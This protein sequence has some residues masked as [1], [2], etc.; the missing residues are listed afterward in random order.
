MKPGDPCTLVCEPDFGLD[1]YGRLDLWRL[2]YEEALAGG[3][4]NGAVRGA[5]SCSIVLSEERFTLGVAVALLVRAI[6]AKEG[7]EGHRG[8]AVDGCRTPTEVG[9][10]GRSLT[11]SSC[12]DDDDDE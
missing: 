11:W 3:R 4:S 6:P 8:S 1:S 7:I 5:C 2:G 9:E 12:H 10:G